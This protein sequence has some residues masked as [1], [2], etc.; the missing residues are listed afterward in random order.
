[1]D[2]NTLPI[3]QN[4]QA[5]YG[6]DMASRTDWIYRLNRQDVDEL[7]QAIA[8]AQ[9]TGVDLLALRREHFPLSR[10]AEHLRELRRALLHGRGFFVVRGVPVERYSIEQAAIAFLGMGHY[11]GE[12]VSQN[13]KGHILGH[14][15]N[16]G[17]DFKDPETRGYQTN[18]RLSYH[19]DYSDAVGLLCLQT[20]RSGGESSIV[21]STT[22]WNELVKRRPDL[23]QA[24]TA[25]LHYTRWGEIP[26]GRKRYSAVPVFTPWAGRMIAFLNTR[27]TIMK[28]QAFAEVPRLLARQI[29][30]LDLLD[31]L[32]N[33]PSIR[34]DMSFQPGDMQY[35]CNHFILHARNVYEDWPEPQRRRHLLRLWLACDDGPDLPPFMTEDFQGK[36]AGGRP[37]GIDVPGVPHKAPLEAE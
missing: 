20:S 11:L 9:T 12:P 37:N 10:L 24:M 28:A 13:G 33:D 8:H 36:T 26:A 29:E 5:W 35:V 4:A 22:L 15:K 30:A 23:A 21:S 34:L 27:N 1:M 17:L 7:D 6:P 2:M 31:A 18:A 19:T 14:V 3:F 25:P 16:L 32:E